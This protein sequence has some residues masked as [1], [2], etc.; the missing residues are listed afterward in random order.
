MRILIIEDEN[1]I[2][3]R[4]AQQLRQLDY[5]VD[6]TGEGEEGL[7]F[8]EEYPIDLAIVDLGLPGVSG[9]DVIKKLRKDGKTLP[10]LILTARDRW[11]DKV[12]GLEAGADDYL[13]KPFQME[14][15]LAR[16]K[17]L[18]RRA[19]GAT[20]ETISCGPIVLELE[21]QQVTLDGKTIDFTTF[22]YRL[23]EYLMRNHQKVISK[24]NLNDYLYP[25]DEDRDSNVIEVIM[26]RVRRKLDP[27]NL[28]KPIE[29]LR[30]RGYRF[31]LCDKNQ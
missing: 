2:R 29:T 19:S 21:S 8:A 30:G 6:E 4:V 25:H 31:T 3:Q 22:E 27:D 15:L 5:M 18:L 12:N 13:V 16:V 11:Q 1:E 24:N 20:K 23:L 9:I 14:E 7:F 17:A 10:I 26:G 28:L